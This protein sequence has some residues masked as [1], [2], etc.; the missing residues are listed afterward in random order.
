LIRGVPLLGAN[1]EISKWF[2]TCT[3][4]EQIKVAEQNLKESEAK[5]AGIISISADAIISIDDDQRITMFN[6]GAEQIFRYSQ[7]EAIGTPLDRLIPERF[8]GVHRQHVETFASG[9]SIA[10]RM[11][12]RLTTIAGLR[13]N[14]E[15]FPAEAAI[16]KLQVGEKTLLTVALRD[17]T[18]RKRTE[19][20]LKAANA[21]LDAIVDN[22]PLML[23]IKD[24]RSLRFVRFN[25]AGEEL[26]GWP[27]ET[28]TGKSDYDFWPRAQADFFTERDRE[29]LTSRKIV[30]I[31]EE[32]IQTRHQGV[33][34]LHTKKVPILDSAGLPIYLL[35]ISE[36]ITERSLIEKEQ[37]FL[38]EASVVLSASLDYE[39]T[40]ATVARLTVQNFADWCAVDVMEEGGSL[41][42]LKV[43]SADPSKAELCAWL[44][45]MPPDRDLPYLMRS[46]VESKRPVLIEH[47]TAQYIRSMSQGPEHPQALE[48]T[49]ITS[50]VA[51]P[52]LLGG[53]ALGAIAL[54]S[55]TPARAYGQSDLRLAEALADRAAVAIENARLYRAAVNATQL[56][57][58]VLRVVAHDLRNPLSVILLQAGALKRHG[59]SPERRSQKPVDAIHSAAT[60][61]NRL[62]QDL[63]D[64]AVMEAGQ[65]TI[66]AA[67]LSARELIAA[68]VDLQRPLASSAFL[69]L[70]IDVEDE[71]PD[72]WGDRDRLL[73]VFENLI[74]N[75]I[76]FTEAGG[77]ITV[78]ATSRDRDVVFWVADTG[79][80]IAPEDLP[81]V[82][83]RFWQAT[84]IGRQGAGLGLPITKGIVE[85]HGGRVWVDSM[86]VLG[87]TFSFTIPK[88]KPGDRSRPAST[89]YSAALTHQ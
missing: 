71:V 4:I 59:P 15:E 38:A 39:E 75:A 36:D 1:G 65:L 68:A 85:A 9:D 11:G 45:Q 42:R 30:D 84:R 16:S 77:R 87:T 29:A 73:Q 72:I 12:E 8:R 81:R 89:A 35:G 54:G 79:S 24:S 88:D 69:E 61:M 32:E 40:L 19:E 82:F 44:E 51:A 28:L 46:V 53:R 2:G 48:A 34:I 20:A 5:F 76:K 58:Q 17:I 74:G 47:V 70:R 57:D 43:A 26:L 50:L 23:F 62:I 10:R 13:E 55:S 31:P 22:V 56:R 27:R 33:R 49:G 18:E 14:G 67:R 78:G 63:L 25:R 60:R 64:V 83:D 80:G 86:P 66:Q 7:A 52:L 3:D 41:R 21:S 37:R 6:H